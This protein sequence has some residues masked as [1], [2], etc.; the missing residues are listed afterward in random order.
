MSAAWRTG[1]VKRPAFS[2]DSSTSESSRALREAASLDLDNVS[3]GA[4]CGSVKTHT[5]Q[6]VIRFSFPMG[7]M[8]FRIQAS[9]AWCKFFGILSLKF[10]ASA[11]EDS[12][13]ILVEDYRAFWI[14]AY[15]K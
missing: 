9:S 8:Q 1:Y 13:L 15:C 12:H 11:T 14:K 4:G 7:V 2:S 3:G 6:V 5:F 10:E